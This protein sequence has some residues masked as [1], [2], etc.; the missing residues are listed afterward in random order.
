MSW[1]CSTKIQAGDD[2]RVKLGAIQVSRATPTSPEMDEQ[3]RVAIEAAAEIV[4]SG[5]LGPHACT[6]QLSGHANLG[7]V[8]APGFSNDYIAVTVAALQ[9]E[10]VPVPDAPSIT[11]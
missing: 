5:A 4:S 7:H 2:V 6:V 3:V 8:P 9:D 10:P 11:G 1:S